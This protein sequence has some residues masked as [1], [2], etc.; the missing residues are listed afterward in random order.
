MAN[1]VLE[2]FSAWTDKSTHIIMNSDIFLNYIFGTDKLKNERDKDCDFIKIKCVLFHRFNA[3]VVFINFP[4]FLFHPIS[5]L[6][7]HDPA[8]SGIE[9]GYYDGDYL[10]GNCTT[11]MSNPAPSVMWY[12]NDHKVLSKPLIAVKSFFNLFSVQLSL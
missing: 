4:H 6:P 5:V 1:N 8:I 11:D 9:K 12:I 2:L 7:R 10:Q 3:F